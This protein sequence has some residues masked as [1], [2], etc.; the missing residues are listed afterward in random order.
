MAIAT[1]AGVA[2]LGIIRVSGKDAIAI[3]NKVFKGRNLENADSHTV[4]YGYITDGPHTIDEVMVTV[5][6]APKSFTTE[7]SLEIACHGSAFILEAVVNVL[8]KN[9]AR[10][11][12]PGEFT[13]RAFMKGRIDLA[14]AEAVADL[15]VSQNEAQHTL[16]MRQMR[17]GITGEI[18]G[19]R[20][21][22]LD[23]VSLIELE[24]DFGEEDVEFANRDQL[25]GL[26]NK[27]TGHIDPLIASFKYGN[28][29]K[30]GIPTAIIGRPNAGKSSLL[31][32]LLKDER[33][34]V[35]DIAGTTRDTI[36]EV[37]NISGTAFRF[38][39]TA[40]IR[41]TDDTIEKIGISKALK[42]IDE[43]AIVLYIFDVSTTN[44]EAVFEDLKMIGERN[45]DSKLMILANKTD[46]VTTEKLSNI[47]AE[48]KSKGYESVF[49][50]QVSGR[51]GA[52]IEALIGALEHEASQ[53]QAG[54]NA[55]IV[56]NVRHYTAL[57]QA[58]A[59]LQKVTEG[60][61]AGISSD[62]LSLDI[63]QALQSLG[64]ITGEVTSDEILG[65]IFGK[66][67]IG[68]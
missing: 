56:S 11:A 38:I 33:A 39:D 15:I 44:T 27:I 52:H 23:F 28:A 55:T 64:E 54:D 46:L 40:G 35:S 53:M 30:S 63:R 58:R 66:F 19:L 57:K 20:S 51:A 43:A 2:A 26:I 24:L 12:Q 17:G 47:A 21:E 22:L 42:K 1:A 4:H 67:C 41:A 48:I 50:I 14:Q 10:L 8:I 7:D 9:G 62:L 60:I 61:E 36:E 29:I 6:R 5:F 68:K 59:A 65:N 13:I 25:V 16:A 49:F 31:N 34:I 32:L 37:L 3:G 18:Q 45:A